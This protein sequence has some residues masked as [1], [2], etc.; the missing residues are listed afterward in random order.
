MKHEK[1]NWNPATQVW[2]CT[3]CGRTSERSTET[4]ACS[5]LEQHDCQIPWVE[6]PAE[7]FDAP[8]E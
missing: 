1:I 2:F 6:V 4:D 5:E 7:L 8:G 3:N